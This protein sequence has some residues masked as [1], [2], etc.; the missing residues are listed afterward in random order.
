MAKYLAGIVGGVFQLKWRKLVAVDDI[1]RYMLRK[2]LRKVLIVHALTHTPANV[3]VYLYRGYKASCSPLYL[4]LEDGCI[5]LKDFYE[6]RY[7]F[8]GH[9]AQKLIDW[10][11]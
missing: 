3:D 8:A 5:L 7:K 11:L 1:D 4:S 6:V 10:L 9:N 2:D